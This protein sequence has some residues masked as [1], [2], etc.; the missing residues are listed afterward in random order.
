MNILEEF[1]GETQLWNLSLGNAQC[2]LF[3]LNI[4]CQLCYKTNS[5]TYLYT[6]II[7]N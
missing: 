3:Q 4:K 5:I 7:V 6:E 1:A 2:N